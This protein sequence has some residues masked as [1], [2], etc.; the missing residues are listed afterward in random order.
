MGLVPDPIKVEG[1]KLHKTPS[2][3]R[4]LGIF[5][6]QCSLKRVWLG[7]DYF[8]TRALPI[9]IGMQRFRIVYSF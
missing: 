8:Q 5:C 1:H 9:A 3:L 6:S 2:W 4:S 7:L